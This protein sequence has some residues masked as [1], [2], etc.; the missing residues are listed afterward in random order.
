MDHAVSPDLL[1]VAGRRFSGGDA[2][3]F[4]AFA[5]SMRNSE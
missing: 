2:T 4:R 3:L 1:L 5:E